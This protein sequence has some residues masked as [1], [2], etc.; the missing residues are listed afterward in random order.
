MTALVGDEI[1][2]AKAEIGQK[3][4]GIGRGAAAGAAAGAFLLFALV[5]GAH[6]LAW[7][8]YS[9][10]GGNHVWLGYLLA[11]IIFVV[12]GAIAGFLAYRALSKSAP[13]VP[14]MAIAEAQA[15]KQAVA[16]ARRSA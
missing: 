6:F 14:T 8:L 13:P 5:L 7:G 15:T 1:E 11:T 3:I 2:L 10:L 9:L 12:L 16:D 4:S